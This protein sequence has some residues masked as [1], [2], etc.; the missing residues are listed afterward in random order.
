MMGPGRQGEVYG[1]T[2]LVP[3]GKKNLF[4]FNFSN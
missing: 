1:I 3:G 2:A 4:I